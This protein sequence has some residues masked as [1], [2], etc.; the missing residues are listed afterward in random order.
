MT[1]ADNFEICLTKKHF[2]PKDLVLGCRNIEEA[3]LKNEEPILKHE[4]IVLKNCIGLGNLI[5]PPLLSPPRR[6]EEKTSKLRSDFRGLCFK[7]LAAF[8]TGLLSPCRGEQEWG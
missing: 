7:K 5:T 3:S 4:G 6:G 2:E 8:E 1:L